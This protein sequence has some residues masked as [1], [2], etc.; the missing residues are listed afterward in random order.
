M[1]Y[2]I[3]HW[4]GEL[5]LK[6]SFWQNVVVFSFVTNLINIVIS[7]FIPIEN[8]VTLAKVSLSYLIAE[9]LIIYP[10]QIV[11]LWRSCIRHIV[12][13]KKV[14]WARLIQGIVIVGLFATVVSINRSWIV[15][16]TLF[17]LGFG[18]AQY[19][20]FEVKLVNND[21]YIQIQGNLGFGISDDVRIILTEKPDIKGIILN[22]GGGRI[23]EAR[24]LSKL[25]I[26]HKLN[27]YS[28]KECFSAC[29]IVYISGKKR[30]LGEGA[31]LAFHKYSTH[32]NG[33][34]AIID[35]KEEQRKDLK[36]FKF[37]GI[38]QKFL[39][40][41]YSAANDDIWLPTVNELLKSGVVH[42]IIDQSAIA[43]IEYTKKKNVKESKNVFAEMPFYKALKKIDPK[44]YNDINTKLHEQIAKGA[45]QIELNR[46]VA[47]SI[48]PLML[49]MLPKS[50]D[51]NLIKFFRMAVDVMKIFENKEPILCLK[52]LYPKEYG[53][54]EILKFLPE[55]YSETMLKI[56]E[57][58]LVNADKNNDSIVNPE[59]AEKSGEDVLE[60]LGDNLTN[61][62]NENLKN[63]K[64]YS[65][66]CN[67]LIKYYS[68][69][70]DKDKKEAG[71]LLRYLIS[72]K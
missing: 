27:T 16:K 67:A 65:N 14:F 57:D 40:Q 28:F 62:Q 38:E 26:D 68:L 10:W 3:K 47:S 19:D 24:K 54:T 64:D 50:S 45:S 51:E 4:R 36:L 69:V 43:P 52:F 71:N 1:N 46:T 25:I 30:Y 41:I 44:L 20:N 29:T 21:L 8:P 72:N 12:V 7:K 32:K 34:D 2:I 60:L 66:H 58:I 55:T 48:S 9:A 35:I 59:F 56:F 22:S 53:K 11:G 23:Y 42:K 18:E 33:L 63:T 17:Q 70:F 13:V 6:V 5:S 49:K 15:Y 61:L 31:N 37:R 39:E